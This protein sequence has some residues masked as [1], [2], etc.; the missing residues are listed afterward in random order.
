MWKALN[1]FQLSSH[2]K[3]RS[4]IWNTNTKCILFGFY[5]FAVGNS[6]WIMTFLMLKGISLNILQW[7]MR[8]EGNLSTAKEEI[9]MDAI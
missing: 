8:R 3:G 9:E 1:K 5:F 6:I 2:F 4:H 7:N